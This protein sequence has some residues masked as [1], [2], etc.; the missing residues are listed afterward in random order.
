MPPSA[1]ASAFVSNPHDGGR[2]SAVCLR[3]H[4]PHKLGQLELAHPGRLDVHALDGPG[5]RLH[6]RRGRPGAQRRDLDHQW[7]WKLDDR[8]QLV[9][10]SDGSQQRHGDVCRR[11]RQSQRPITVTLDG[12]QSAGGLVFNVSGSGYTLRRAPA[13]A[14]TLGTAAGGSISV[15]SGTHTISAP[16]VLAGSLAVSTTGGG[17]LDL[18]GSVSEATPGAGAITLN[19][20]ELILSGTRQ[21]HR[22]HDG[23]QR[24]ALPDELHRHRRRDELDRGRRRHVHLRSLAGRRPCQRRFVCGVARRGCGGPGTGNL[25][26]IQPGWNRYR[27]SGLAEEEEVMM[28]GRGPSSQASSVAWQRD[29]PASLPRNCLCTKQSPFAE[30]GVCSLQVSDD[31]IDSGNRESTTP[32]MTDG[33]KTPQ[34]SGPRTAEGMPC[35]VFLSVGSFLEGRSP[36]MDQSPR[37]SCNKQ[38]EKTRFSAIQDVFLF[39]PRDCGVG[40]GNGGQWKRLAAMGRHGSAEYVFRGTTAFLHRSCRARKARMDRGSICELPKM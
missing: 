1:A 24:D 40:V 7:Q 34:I 3:Q 14:L 35:D 18:S 31:I 26:P 11:S 17:V 4:E 6:R 39:L 36:R 30:N 33:R 19:G 8:Q 13:G 25:G 21:L 22:R 38:D 9:L 10:Q 2:L 20:G 5:P 37:N 28:I 15:L 29:S 23:Q 12:N 32:S 16:V 27:G